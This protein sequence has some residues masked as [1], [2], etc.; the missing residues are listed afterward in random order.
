MSLRHSPRL[1]PASLAARR[2]NALKS[3]GPRTQCGK[4]RVA[5]NPL[6]HGRRAV[7][8]QEKLAR[9][10]GYREGEALYCR[11]RGLRRPSLRHGTIPTVTRDR[12]ANWIWVVQRE[13]RRRVSIRTNPECALESGTGTARLT[14]TITAAR[15]DHAPESASTTI[16]G[17]SASSSTPTQLAAQSRL[18]VKI[19]ALPHHRMFALTEQNGLTWGGHEAQPFGGGAGNRM[20]FMPLW[21]KKP[22]PPTPESHNGS[23]EASPTS[24]VSSDLASK[25]DMAFSSPSDLSRMEKRMPDTTPRPAPANVSG[26]PASVLGRSIALKGELTGKEDLVVEGQFEGTIDVA[27]HTVTVGSQ[28]QVKSEIRARHVVVHGSVTGK[29][30]AREKIDIRRTGNVTGDLVS[31]GVAIED[32]AYFKGSIEILRE[33]RAEPAR[34]PLRSQA[35]AVK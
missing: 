34:E 22:R 21:E 28:G 13:W 27:E 25:P 30:T 4:A 10:G 5:L 20:E 32:G 2:A 24:A 8:L 18:Y 14:L 6:K 9:A 31:A 1:T 23:S 12:L 33:G 19:A 15:P 35:V 7:A 16:T 29:I 3:T 11:I 17:A 26:Q